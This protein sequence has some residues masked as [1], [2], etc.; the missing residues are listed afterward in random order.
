MAWG[1]SIYR[2]DNPDPRPW[3]TN[4]NPSQRKGTYGQ[5]QGQAMVEASARQ[6]HGAGRRRVRDAASG[7][8]AR[9]HAGRGHVQL[10][11][12]RGRVQ[13]AGRLRDR[14]HHMGHGTGVQQLSRVRRQHRRQPHDR[15][16]TGQ[17]QEVRPV[18]LR[19]GRF[20]RS[21]GPILLAE[22]VE[23]LASRHRGAR[24]GDGRQPRMG[25]L[26]L[27]TPLHGRV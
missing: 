27:G 15:P 4:N 24:L 19:D 8:R 17:R 5:K 2:P 9:G 1:F 11:V 25:Q 6:G 26:G 14:R 7:Y 3:A 16:G 12:R 23:L 22:Y 20:A 21:R 10:A 13:H 18:S